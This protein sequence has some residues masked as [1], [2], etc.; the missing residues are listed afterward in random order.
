M[1]PHSDLL[2]E[3]QDNGNY[4]MSLRV[5]FVRPCLGLMDRNELLFTI[6]G[7]HLRVPDLENNLLP[8]K[9]T[10]WN[11]VYSRVAGDIVFKYVSRAF[12]PFLV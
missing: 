1:L 3:I 10:D 8:H 4:G 7:F 9:A 2:V 12:E 11:P 5:Q 6:Q